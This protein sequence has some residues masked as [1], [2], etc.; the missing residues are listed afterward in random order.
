MSNDE[1]N[2]V[3]SMEIHAILICKDDNKG[4]YP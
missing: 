1:E 4:G 2:S 3:L